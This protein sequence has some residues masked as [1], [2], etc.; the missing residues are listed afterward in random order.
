MRQIYESQTDKSNEYKVSEVISKAWKVNLHKLPISYRLDFLITKDNKAKAIVEIKTRKNSYNKYPT[1]LLSL[2]KWNH[3]IEYT[4]LNK[5][6]FIL[7][8]MFTDGIFYY[9]YSDQDKFEIKWGGRTLNTRD[10][11]DIEPVVHIPIEKM[12]KI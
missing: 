5:L 9:T 6:K 11:A 4:V 10:S 12:L 3:G 1:L 2:S 8:V 7:V